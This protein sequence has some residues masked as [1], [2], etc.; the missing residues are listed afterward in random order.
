MAAQASMDEDAFKPRNTLG[1]TPPGSPPKMT[2]S[3]LTGVDLKHADDSHDTGKAEVESGSGRD[4]FD[5]TREIDTDV[6]D[7]EEGT[8][9]AKIKRLDSEAYKPFGIRSSAGADQP[10]YATCQGGPGKK[11]GTK[12]KCGLKVKDN[13]DGVCC[14]GCKY[15]F[16]LGCQK[17]QPATYEA[18]QKVKGLFWICTECRENLPRLAVRKGAAEDKENKDEQTETK[19]GK[20]KE[21]VDQ[22][23]LD[24]IKAQ[25]DEI[26]AA[27]KKQEEAIVTNIKVML[28]ERTQELPA[29]SYA[30]A[31]KKIEDHVS[32]LQS[33][34]GDSTEISK[35]VN[36]IK[37]S[38]EEQR[39]TLI[40]MKEG[41]TRQM[42]Q[43]SQVLENN[44]NNLQKVVRQKEKEN[45]AQNL[46]F[47]NIE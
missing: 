20:M 36:E 12:K 40:G 45:R 25:K 5:D 28:P 41:M 4:A 29:K 7:V 46:V 14:D 15:W 27:M 16:H 42:A 33:V 18:L 2:E 21:R 10:S 24:A 30:E 38:S 17:V 39:E 8:E 1:R 35:I 47:H 31:A 34:V 19:E 23:V 13:E 6:E 3:V 37:Q 43:Q 44:S 32:K 9:G 26:L 11:K 22:A